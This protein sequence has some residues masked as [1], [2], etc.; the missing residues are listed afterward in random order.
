MGT[1]SFAPSSRER[2][3]CPPAQPGPESDLALSGDS[4]GL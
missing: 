2:V 3:L 1:L 4:A